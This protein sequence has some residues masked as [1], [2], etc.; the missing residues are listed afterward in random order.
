MRYSFHITLTDEDYYG[1]NQFGMLQLPYGKRQV[2]YARIM[3]AVSILLVIFVVMLGS[4][5]ALWARHTTVILVLFLL[6]IEFAFTPI[7]KHALKMHLK[8]IRKSGKM[9][10]SPS[11]VIEFYEDRFI[12]TT[13]EN[14]TEQLYS[15][16][17]RISVIDNKII[18]LHIN[19]LMAYLIPV[20][21]F[22][23]TS[24]YDEFLDF[25]KTK[26]STIHIYDD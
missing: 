8:Q 23:S 16:V 21:S 3:I 2:N 4:E 18:Y 10:Y 13:A 17:E 26:C 7:L 15:S 1:F 14:K 11:S 5:F 9:P 20:A 19:N 6:I 22:E 12:E 25:M 24:Q